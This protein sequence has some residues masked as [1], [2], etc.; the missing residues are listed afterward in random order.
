MILRVLCDSC[1]EIVGAINTETIHYPITGDQILSPNPEHGVPPQFHAS[2]TQNEFRCPFGPRDHQAGHRPFIYEGKF[3]TEFGDYFEV[4]KPYKS[5]NSIQA[6]NQSVI[7]EMFPKTDEK[8]PQK[9][10]YYFE[11]NLKSGDRKGYLL[12]PEEKP[13]F[14]CQYCGKEYAHQPSRSRHEKKC[15]KKS[16][17]DRR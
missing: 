2:L 11:A 12:K 1:K 8:E 4:G 7:D 17:N 3:K 9:E 13:K 5:R 16:R 15:K 14:T 6:R 10:Q